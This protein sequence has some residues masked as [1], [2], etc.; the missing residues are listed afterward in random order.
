M[1]TTSFITVQVITP[2][3]EILKIKVQGSLHDELTWTIIYNALQ[4]DNRI[5][6]TNWKIKRIDY[7]NAV[8]VFVGRDFQS[9]RVIHFQYK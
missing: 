2:K 8:E 6:F 9:V 7:Q 5:D 1:A 4:K 3:G